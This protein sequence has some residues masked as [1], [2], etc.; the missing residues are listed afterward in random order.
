MVKIFE[1]YKTNGKNI[2]NNDDLE[3]DLTE[4]DIGLINVH[5]CIENLK[6][7]NYFIT[8]SNN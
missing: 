1:L 7:Q 2:R 3:S 8:N 6:A 4:K 5:F